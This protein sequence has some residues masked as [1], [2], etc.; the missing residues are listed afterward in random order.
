MCTFWEL[1]GGS[2]RCS[3]SILALKGDSANCCRGKGYR[4]AFIP[5]PLPAPLALMLLLHGRVIAATAN[6]T[7][8]EHRLQARHTRH[9]RSAARSGQAALRGQPFLFFVL[10]QITSLRNERELVKTYLSCCHI[11]QHSGHTGETQ[12]TGASRIGK[13]T[14]YPS[15]CQANGHPCYLPSPL[16][17]K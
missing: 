14:S 15:S 12:R 8:R 13:R 1:L 5:L 10:R 16:R 2:R 17:W 3:A 4:R 6:P 9:F 7:V 11:L